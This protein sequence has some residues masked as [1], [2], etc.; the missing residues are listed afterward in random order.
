MQTHGKPLVDASL[1]LKSV[2]HRTN[3]SNQS[4]NDVFFDNLQAGIVHGNIA[5][6]NHYYAYGLKIA[7]LSSK[8]LGDVYEG[9]LKN[10]YLYQGAFSELDDDIGWTDFMLRN[11]DAQIGRWV[12]QDPYQQFASPYVGMGNDPINNTD[13]SGGVVI[14]P[15]YKVL[16]EVVVTSVRHTSTVVSAASAFSKIAKIGN[17]TAKVYQV[18]SILNTSFTTTAVIE[19]RSEIYQRGLKDALHNAL[20]FGIPE[21]FGTNLGDYK[22]PYDQEA[23]LKGR[24]AGDEIAITMSAI[25]MDGAITGGASTALVTGGVGAVAAVGVGIHSAATA[26]IATLDVIWAMKKLLRLNISSTASSDAGSTPNTGSGSSSSGRVARKKPSPPEFAKDAKQVKRNGV[27]GW[28]DK[29]GNFITKGDKPGEWH[30]NPSRGNRK[31]L[32]KG[33]KPRGNG[34]NRYWN[35]KDDGTIHH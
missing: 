6:E 34:D 33:Q 19:P 3:R 14:D 23:Y 30:V 16:E 35:V 12:Q 11:Y 1:K 10:N 29:K 8:K 28:E 13:P 32:W 25:E 24:L 22:D 17:I 27:R 7:T 4:N 9:S 15:V 20:F 2:R 5:E 21:I 18:A 31:P 26:G